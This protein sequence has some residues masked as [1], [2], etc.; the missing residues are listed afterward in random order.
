MGVKWS[1][2][3]PTI[4]VGCPVDKLFA[5]AEDLRPVGAGGELIKF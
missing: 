3:F 4:A 5:E 2:D 1:R